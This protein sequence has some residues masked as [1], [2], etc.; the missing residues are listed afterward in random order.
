MPRIRSA[1]TASQVA[2]RAR[3]EPRPVLDRYL[4][5]RSANASPRTIEK[6]RSW[7]GKWDLWLAGRHRDPQDATREDAEA[8]M[9]VWMRWGWAPT[10]RRQVIC[11]C[12][13]FHR[14]L[15]AHGLAQRNPWDGIEGPR[16]PK[17]VPRIV[18]P[19]EMRAMDAALTRPA[20]RDIRDHAMLNFLRST[21]CRVGEMQ[22][23]RFEDLDLAHAQ[24]RVIGKG[25][26]ERIVYMDAATTAAIREW[27]D[28]GRP[29]WARSQT[30][31][32]FLGRHGGRL[33]Y[34]AVRDA[35][36]RAEQRANVRRHI[37]PHLFRHTY[38]TTVLESGANIRQLQEL[39][40]HEH[41]SSTEVYLH[42]RPTSLREAHG[43]AFQ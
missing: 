43:R 6:L 8:W 14:W 9:A 7:L 27:I 10:T 23:L 35:L 17:R 28:T 12:R 29:R 21:G 1:A 34:T 33:N 18:S 15:V 31:W 13:T 39:L 24:A 30:G 19:R 20:V 42:V 37:N 41:L 26:K 16:K 22:G 4:S 38:A 3:P 2:S 40:G 5:Y 36:L 32:V 25:D 11:D